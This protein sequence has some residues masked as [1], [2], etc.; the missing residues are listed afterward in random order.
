MRFDLEKSIEVL[1]STPEMLRAFLQNLSD[2]WIFSN[3]GEESWSPYE[4]VGHLIHG[5]KTDWI[6]R[7]EIILSDRADKTFEPF[8]RFAQLESEN[9]PFP[10]LL[11]EFESLRSEN[12]RILRSKNIT[13]EHLKATGIHPAF[14]EVTLSQLL[15]TWVAHDLGHIAQISR[16][17]AK[18][19]KE[20]VGPWIAYLRVLES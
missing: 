16:V 6:P 2:D 9:Q 4:V 15:S 7:M 5:E 10:A 20:E 1:E 8:D 12:I 3:E 13:E 18:Q 14:G 19:Y 11:D 17:L